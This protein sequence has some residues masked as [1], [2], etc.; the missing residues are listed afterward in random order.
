MKLLI[1]IV[2]IFFALSGA[3]LGS[4]HPI[5]DEA[6]AANGAC[7]AYEPRFSYYPET[8]QCKR[9]IFNGCPIN[10]NNFI[11]KKQCEDKCKE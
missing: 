1:A 6:P 7:V 11:T 8:K 10:A 5:C 3:A 4:K 9:F 2:G